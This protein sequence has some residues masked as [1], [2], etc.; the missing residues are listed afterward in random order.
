MRKTKMVLD[1][2]LEKLPEVFDMEDIRSDGEDQA[3]TPWWPSRSE[4]G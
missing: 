2:M 4:K 3:L 1:E